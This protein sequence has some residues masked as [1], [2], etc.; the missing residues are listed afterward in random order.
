MFTP[1][2]LKAATAR[3]SV[4]AW[5]CRLAEAAKLVDIAAGTIAQIVQSVQHVAGIV[6]EIT[7]AT[8]EQS[9]GIDLVNVAV[10]EMDQVTQQN[11][12]LVEQVAAA[13][14]SMST[15]VQRLVSDVSVF[16]L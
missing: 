9:A 8:V 16:R 13:A 1:S 6:S 4:W 2:R 7:S 12:A 5:S 14:D 10:S 15:Q 3:I 11:A